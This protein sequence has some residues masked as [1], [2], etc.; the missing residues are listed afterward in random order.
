ITIWVGSMYGHPA[1]AFVHST[2]GILI[3]VA[4]IT[5]FWYLIV[6]WLDKSPT[7]PTPTAQTD[8]VPTTK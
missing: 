1:L 4:F 8:S 3:F 2:L 5:V 6:R 7:E